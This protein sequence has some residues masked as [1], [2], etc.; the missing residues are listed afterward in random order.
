MMVWSLK[1]EEHPR[2]IEFQQGISSANGKEGKCRGQTLSVF[3]QCC[4]DRQ[5][6]CTCRRYKTRKSRYF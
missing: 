6:I 5:V 1:Y 3:E 2:W 4:F